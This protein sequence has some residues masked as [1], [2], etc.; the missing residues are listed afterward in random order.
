MNIRLFK[1]IFSKNNIK[2]YLEKNMGK[3]TNYKLEALKWQEIYKLK[4]FLQP[5]GIWHTIGILYE[6]RDIKEGISI[7]S[8][9]RILNGFS[10]YNSFLRVKNNMIEKELIDIYTKESINSKK[11]REYIKITEKGIKVFEFLIYFKDKILGNG[12]LKKEDG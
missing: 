1:C 6:F 4:S 11:S 10:Y 2:K 3:N 8:F 9:Y 12:K 7:K 5:I